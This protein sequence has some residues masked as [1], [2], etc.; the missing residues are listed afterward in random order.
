MLDSTKARSILDPIG[1][2]LDEGLANESNK[3]TVFHGE[4]APLWV[5]IDATGA[6]GHGSRFIK[7]TATSKLV[8]LAN[9]ALEFRA[10]EEK[11]MGYTTTHTED[12]GCAHCE[13]KKLGEV[14]TLNLTVLQAGVG[15]GKTSSEYPN[16]PF[17][18]LNVIP[19]QARA[20]FDIRVPP[21][22]PIKDVEAMLDAWCSAEEGLSWHYAPWTT[23]MDKH[24]VSSV[25][26]DMEPWW[27]VFED[28]IASMGIKVSKIL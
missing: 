16:D 1:I 5:F 2:A 23:P 26:R 27:G 17:Y 3:Y 28:S 25:D 13:A 22:V 20:G 10:I 15:G 12:K 19:N 18:A 14:T 4:R 6:T 9:K 21:A 8:N 7:D 11:K 24:W